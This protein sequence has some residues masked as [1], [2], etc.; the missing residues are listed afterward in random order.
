MYVPAS[1]H[2]DMLHFGLDYRNRAGIC[3]ARTLWLL[4]YADRATDVAKQT[5]R[6]AGKLNHPL[7]LC[8]ALIWAVSVYLWN[9]DWENAEESIEQ[10]ISHARNRALVPYEAAGIGVRGYLAVMRGDHQAGLPML[11]HALSEMHAHHYELMTTAFN[12]AL[13]EGL[14]MANQAKEALETIDEALEAVE[15]NGDLFNVA[16]LLRIKGQ[17]FAAGPTSDPPRAEALFL[18]SLEVARASGA[19]AWE[20]RTATSLAGFWRA[21][22]RSEEGVR[23]L[24][25]VLSQFTEGFGCSDFVKATKMLD[26]CARL[27]A[28]I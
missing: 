10:L 24:R 14:L 20:L 15:R 26:E 2:V 8:I 22:R 27:A 3:L 18:Q 28:V 13:A 23:L 19:L 7:T 21:Q 4:G 6:E 11:R 16:E 25:S 9:G 5:A 1:K 12:S 17:I